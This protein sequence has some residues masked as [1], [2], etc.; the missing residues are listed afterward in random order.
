MPFSPFSLVAAQDTQAAPLL[1]LIAA[2]RQSAL[3]GLRALAPLLA[4]GVASTIPGP[5]AAP[6]LPLRDGY[7]ALGVPSA[8]AVLGL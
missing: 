2:L 6:L 8:L 4:L 7:A 5:G 1:Y 3:A